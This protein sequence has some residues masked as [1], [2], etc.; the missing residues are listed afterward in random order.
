MRCHSVGCGTAVLSGG[1]PTFS[2]RSGY[3]DAWL[4]PDVMTNA[5]KLANW[6]RARL[7]LARSRCRLRCRL[8]DSSSIAG[9][10]ASGAA[11]AHSIVQPRIGLRRFQLLAFAASASELVDRLAALP[12]E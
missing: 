3:A 9:H 11:T 6:P 10:E 4:L 7:A 5:R 8:L 12:D 2:K 1:R